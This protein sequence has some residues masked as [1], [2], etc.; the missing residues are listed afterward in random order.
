MSTP[1][2]ETWFHITVTYNGT[3]ASACVNGTCV[4]LLRIG[5]TEK[6]IHRPDQPVMFFGKRDSG[7]MPRGKFHLDNIFVFPF[8]LD[9]NHLVSFQ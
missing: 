3:A 5:E 6:V 8:L 7:D 9:Q 4:D 2:L 1:E